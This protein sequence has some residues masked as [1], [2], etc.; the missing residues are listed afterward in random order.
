MLSGPAAAS[1]S[2]STRPNA[3]T[4]SHSSTSWIGCSSGSI[5]PRRQVVRHPRKS[6]APLAAPLLEHAGRVAVLLVLQQPADQFLPRVFQL[7]LDFLFA[8]QHHPRLDLDQRAGHVEKIAHRVDV[9]LLQHGD[10]FEKLVGDRR[11]RNV[12][13]VELVLAHQIQQQ[14]Q[15][16]AKHLQIDA[17][18]SNH[19]ATIATA[20]AKG[21]ASAS[22]VL[23][24][25]GLWEASPTPIATPDDYH[26]AESATESPPT[27]PIAQKR[28]RAPHLE[29]PGQFGFKSPFG[30]R[31]VHGV[32]QRKPT[33][34][35]NGV[36]EL[37]RSAGLGP[38]PPVQPA[39]QPGPTPL[40]PNRCIRCRSRSCGSGDAADHS[41]ADNHMSC[42]TI[43]RSRNCLRRRIRTWAL[44]H[45]GPLPRSRYCTSFD[46]TCGIH[47]AD[48]G[49]PRS[50]SY[51]AQTSPHWPAIPKPA[52]RRK[53]LPIPTSLESHFASS[54]YP[55][56]TKM[57]LTLNLENGCGMLPCLQDLGAKKTT[58]GRDLPSSRP[59]PTHQRIPPFRL[60]AVNLPVRLI[61]GFS[62]PYR[63]L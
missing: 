28:S 34:D 10:V 63:E 6:L 31:L 61:R 50:R 49:H 20:T 36:Y 22:N 32:K 9:D 27:T 8:R 54:N 17:K 4:R 29:R 58:V 39:P 5:V 41:A 52:A 16:T 56:K 2:F 14:V 18:A 43:S 59:T 62:H 7:L 19:A 3:L 25:P 37:T 30:E 44:L 60:R 42:H 40:R 53:P 11:D 24:T 38:L 45:K 21:E 15:R 47:R 26:N 48:H 33:L 1:F 46:P 23:A 13:H 35:P 55:P 51:H 12:R 57:N